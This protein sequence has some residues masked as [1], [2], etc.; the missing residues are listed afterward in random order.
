[1]F[2]DFDLL[3]PQITWHPWKQYVSYKVILYILGW[4]GNFDNFMI[5][6]ELT[7]FSNIAH[8][9]GQ[10]LSQSL[11]GWSVMGGHVAGWEKIDII[12]T[13]RHTWICSFAVRKKGG[14][15]NVYPF[16]RCPIILTQNQYCRLKP[17]ISNYTLIK[18]KLNTNGWVTISVPFISLSYTN[19]VKHQ[20]QQ[21]QNRQN[22]RT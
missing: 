19:N 13:Y 10:F 17:R 8:P 15:I 2:S 12:M 22:L 3:W 1:M 21:H 6:K 9:N 11:C 18:K 4:V 14:V 5:Q 16:T 7:Q 20:H